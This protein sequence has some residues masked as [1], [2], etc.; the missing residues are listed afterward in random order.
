MLWIKFNEDLIEGRPVNLAYEDKS[1]KT[2][3]VVMSFELFLEDQLNLLK[4]HFLLY[5]TPLVSSTTSERTPPALYSIG[6]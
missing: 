1:Q 4:Y 3:A 5:N 2:D 6:Q